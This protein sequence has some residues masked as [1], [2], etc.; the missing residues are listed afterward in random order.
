MPKA[1]NLVDAYN[2]FV[3]EPLKTEEEFKDF[4]VERPKNAPS[5][6]EELKDRIEN[7][8]SAKKYLFLGFRGCGKST[9]LNRL[10]QLLD[11]DKFLLVSYSI[12][13]LDVSDFDFR[14]FFGSMALKI[15][16][17][18][19]K[20]I[21]LE[22]DIKDDFLDFMMHI[23]KVS[24]EDVT[25]YSEMG[26]SFSNFILLKLGREAKTREYIRKELETKISDLI[27]K[28]NWLTMEVETK[29][30]KRIVVIVDDL[31]KL[32]RVKQ[33]EDFFYKNYGL[34]IQPKC[35]VIYTF[36][37]PLTFNPYYE[38][39]R[40]AFDDDIILPQL[41]VK[42]KD[43]KRLNE[44][45]INF[46][47]GLVEKRMDLDLI[48]ENAL[49]EAIVSTGKT[50]ELILIMRD[51]AIKAYRNENEQI[52]KEEVGKALEKLRRTYDRTLTEAHKKRLLEIY[53]KK[54]ARDEDTSDST[55]RDLL[56]S[57]TAVEYED[58]DGRWCD[59]NPLL[60]PLVEKWKKA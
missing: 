26:I 19:E 9:E 4:Y 46:Y 22:T 44:K 53:D 52:T 15:Y 23:T 38:N 17:I 29:S 31:D 55:S 40:P 49:E 13:E 5:P 24:E 51:A 7:A 35:F 39:V 20:E 8:D 47:K 14:D 30:S 37:I 45:N 36:P 6:I 3:V 33:A 41:P 10:F 11:M 57:L 1:T 28:L 60:M 27:Q 56:F 12:R 16:D 42:S 25:K 32:T 43:G 34:L 59:I 48:E 18:A 21:K 2:N 58:E 50:S 54:E